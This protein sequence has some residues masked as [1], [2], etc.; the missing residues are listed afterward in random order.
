MRLGL[1]DQKVLRAFAEKRSADGDKL[2]TDGRRLD[3]HWLGGSRIA[4]WE[5]GQIHTP[6]RGSR[7]AE[8]IQRQLRRHAAPVEFA[9][10]RGIGGSRR[11][12]RG[13]AAAIRQAKAIN[14]VMK[15]KHGTGKEWFKGVGTDVGRSR[16]SPQ[17][18]RALRQ[19]EEAWLRQYAYD[20]ANSDVYIRNSDRIHAAMTRAFEA[21]ANQAD[22]DRAMDRALARRRVR[23]RA[24]SR[25]TFAR[26]A[27]PSTSRIRRPR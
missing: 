19:V 24:G 7:A 17:L 25:H 23:G 14:R 3:G 11:D 21:G 26:G 18:A 6:D 13:R 16:S 20:G 8:S 10:F 4:Y 9:D 5:D 15:G 2:S 27:R 22:I 12:A 1:S